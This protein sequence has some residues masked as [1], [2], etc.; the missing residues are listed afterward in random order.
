[1]TIRTEK[2]KKR[3]SVI[4][5]IMLRAAA[6]ALAGHGPSIRLMVKWYTDAVAEHSATHE[7]RF[8]LLEDMR[9]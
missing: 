2:S 1:M 6:K 4:E 8:H 3:V 7:K 5:A 9:F